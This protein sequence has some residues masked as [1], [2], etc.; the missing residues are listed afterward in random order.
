MSAIA[1]NPAFAVPMVAAKAAAV[2]IAVI[3]DFF[4]MVLFLRGFL[5]LREKHEG[6]GAPVIVDPPLWRIISDV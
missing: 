3:V 4:K 2:A 1:E 5:K 6:L